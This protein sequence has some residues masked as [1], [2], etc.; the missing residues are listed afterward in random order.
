MVFLLLISQH[1]AQGRAHSGVRV[2][3][4]YLNSALG[5][6]LPV[7]ASGRRYLF[8][9]SPESLVSFLSKHNPPTFFHYSCHVISGG[10]GDTD[11]PGFKSDHPS[12]LLVA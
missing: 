2:C 11:R 1:L 5:L 3:G 12:H 8:S 9:V 10:A 6:I 7:R 4:L